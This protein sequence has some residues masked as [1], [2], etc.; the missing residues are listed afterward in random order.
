LALATA[1]KGRALESEYQC[2]HCSSAIA[3]EDVNVATDLALCRDCGKTS[4]FQQV[5]SMS[6]VSEET[7]DHPPRGIHMMRNQH[8]GRK[9]VFRR[10]SPALLFLVP[11]TAVWAGGS[12]FGIYGTQI[13]EGK[14]DLGQSLFGIP[15]LIG[16][17]VLVSIILFLAFGRWEMVL[18]R[19]TGKVFAGLGKVGWTRRFTYSKATTVGLVWTNVEVN[20]VR[21]RGVCIDNDGEKLTFGS[22]L[23]EEAKEYF[24]AAIQLAIKEL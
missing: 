10:V 4:S 7:L 21:Q 17:I 19:G 9:V 23:R 11:F 12:M 16:S 15:F 8:G 13:K 14:F 24:A 18:D 1:G 22:T 6:S 20:D 5:V 3:P 2:P